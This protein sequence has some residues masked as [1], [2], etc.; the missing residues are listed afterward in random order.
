MTL[1]DDVFIKFVNDTAAVLHYSKP[2]SL[3]TESAISN[4]ESHEEKCFERNL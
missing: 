4:I 1:L 3:M 2:E